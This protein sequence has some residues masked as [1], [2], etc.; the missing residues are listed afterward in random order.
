MS[1]SN[2][3]DDC[4]GAELARYRGAVTSAIRGA[5]GQALLRELLAA[6]DALPDKALIVDAFEFDGDYCALGVVGAARGIPMAGLDPEDSDTVARVF[7]VAKSL[8]REITF[9]NDE[10]G[11]YDETCEQRWQRVRTWVASKVRP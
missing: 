1:R 9:I 5:R 11:P 4:D 2:Y 10:D 7:D 6:L 8:A 3:S